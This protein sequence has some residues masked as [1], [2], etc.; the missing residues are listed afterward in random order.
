MSGGL[1][2]QEEALL[3]DAKEK[4]SSNSFDAEQNKLLLK[5]YEK[6]LKQ[7]RR[8]VKMSDRTEAELNRMSKEQVE[9]NQTLSEQN[10]KLE[11]LSVKLSKYLSP[12][13]MNPSFQERLKYGWEPTGST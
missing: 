3:N 8:L 12:Q 2:K 4:E 10:T 13:Y 11:T 9:L 5:G 1:F 6:L 7:T